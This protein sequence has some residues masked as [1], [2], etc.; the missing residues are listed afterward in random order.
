M[1]GGMASS[2]PPDSPTDRELLAQGGGAWETLVRRHGSALRAF[3]HKRCAYWNRCQV[4]DLCQE[5][6]MA[7]FRHAEQF[8]VGSFRSWLFR[9]ARNKFLD[10]KK[11]KHPLPLADEGQAVGRTKEILVQLA[12]TEEAMAMTRRLQDCLERLSAEERAVVVDRMQGMSSKE[13][14]N[15]MKRAVEQV[16]KLMELGK[17][18][19]MKCVAGDA[20]R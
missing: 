15:T 6:W 20:N 7:V 17:A 8:K 4:D 5:V 19:L 3:L 1:I 2:H 11:K 13:I 16:Y 9:I 14:A 10:A 18:R 12:D